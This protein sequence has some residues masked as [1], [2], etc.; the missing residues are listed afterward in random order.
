MTSGYF[1]ICNKADKQPL[2]SHH[3]KLTLSN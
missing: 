2:R 3:S 1:V